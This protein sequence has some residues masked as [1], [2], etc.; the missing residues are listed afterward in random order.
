[1]PISRPQFR[2]FTELW[3]YPRRWGTFLLVFLVPAAIGSWLL[4]LNR[5]WSAWQLLSALNRPPVAAVI[6]IQVTTGKSVTI[7]IR[8][9]AHDPDGPPPRLLGCEP[10]QFGTVERIDDYHF[11]YSPPPRTPGADLFLYRILDNSGARSDGWVFVN[12]GG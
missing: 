5:D 12:Q 10:P 1:M 11:R 6:P 7:D 2:L 9:H 4:L 8:A 3:L